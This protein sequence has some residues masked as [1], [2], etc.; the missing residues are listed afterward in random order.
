MKETLDPFRV[1]RRRLWLEAGGDEALVQRVQIA[2]IEDRPAP[3]RQ[4][5]LHRL[6]DQVEITAAGA[7]AGEAR[8]RAAVQH[9]EPDEPVKPH[10]GFHVVRRQGDRAEGGDRQNIT[11]L[12]IA[13]PAFRAAKPAL[14]SSSAMRLVISSSR[15]SLQSR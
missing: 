2:F 14:I 15:K 13:S 6:G 4:P 12:R 8:T 9:L 3:P 5:L 10:R 11:T 1:A 7:E